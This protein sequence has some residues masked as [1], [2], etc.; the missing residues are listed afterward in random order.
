[1]NLETKVFLKKKFHEYYRNSRI[2]APR[3]IE[4]REF[5]IGTLESKIKIRHKS[6]KS[7]EEL[8]LYLRREAPFYISYS[9]AYYEFPENQPIENKQWL[10]S[11]LIFDLDTELEFLEREKLEKVKLETINLIDFLVEDFGFSKKDIEVNFSGSKGFH[12]HV[13]NEK[14]RSLD[15][16]ERREIIDYITGEGIDIECFMV[17]ERV[18]GHRLNGKKVMVRKGPDENSTGW[19]KRIY[20]MMEAFLLADVK[21]KKAIIGKSHIPTKKIQEIHEKRED[22]L[23]MIKRGSW[24]GLPLTQKMKERLVENYAITLSK[25]TDRMVTLDITRLIRLPDSLHGGTG[26]KASRLKIKKLDN[27]DPLRDAVVFGDDEIKIEVKTNLDKFEFFDNKFHLKKGL[28]K[29]PEYVA[30]FLM[31]KDKAEIKDH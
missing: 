17:Q 14:V 23:N 7:E 30:I 10:G 22:Y 2:K 24:D 1:M 27:F 29:L 25:D 3:E 20:K 16:E 13:D 4:K 26:L 31:L 9:S 8:N 5:G 11:E 15:K 19:G 12:I 18:K 28:L 21:E 6:F